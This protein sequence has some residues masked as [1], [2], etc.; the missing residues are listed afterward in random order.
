MK[1]RKEKGLTGLH[2]DDVQKECANASALR[3]SSYY[4][5]SHLLLL[6]RRT[7]PHCRR[8]SRE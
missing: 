7:S 5:S 8:G 3:Y 1:K 2:G 4:L 6:P